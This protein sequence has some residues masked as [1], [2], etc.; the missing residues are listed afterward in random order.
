MSLDSQFLVVVETFQ[1]LAP[2]I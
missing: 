2:R 1:I